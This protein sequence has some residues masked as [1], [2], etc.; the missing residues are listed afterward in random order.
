MLTEAG[1]GGLTMAAVIE[2]AG[3][4]SA[5]LYRRWPAK[6]ELVAA[7]IASL[8]PQPLVIDK[9][10]LEGDLLAFVRLLGHSVEARE[11]VLEQLVLDMHLHPEL[12]AAL[13]EKLV[14]PRLTALEGILARAV[15]RGEIVRH[16]P[17][18]VVFSLVCGPVYHRAAGMGETLSPSFLR[19]VAAH[20]LHGLLGAQGTTP[21]R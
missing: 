21:A 5:T 9:G 3:V 4:S 13:R 15:D 12:A 8:A 18:D 1:Y 11:A 16:P 6:Q 17:V 7:A 20:A 10:S 14:A 2:R 19:S